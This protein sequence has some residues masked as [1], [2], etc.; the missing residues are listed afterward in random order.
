MQQIV[1]AY[2]AIGFHVT[3]ILG[4]GGFE[5]IRNGLEDLGIT[6]NVASR[7]EHVP[8]IERYIRTVNERVRA[9]AVSLPFTKHPP[10][11]IAEMVYNVLAE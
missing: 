3:N 11:L 7:N 8:E 6:L 1:W 5:C 2:L 10:R 4:D 9:I